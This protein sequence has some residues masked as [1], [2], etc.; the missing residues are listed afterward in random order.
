MIIDLAPLM[1]E[2]RQDMDQGFLRDEAESW[3][4]WD[5]NPNTRG[6]VDAA[7]SK[8][9]WTTLQVHEDVPPRTLP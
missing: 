3:L 4:K 2:G 1:L 9:D 8:E 7:L 5:P 6:A